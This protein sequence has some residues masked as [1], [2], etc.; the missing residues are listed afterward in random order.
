[1]GYEL[2]ARAW[3]SDILVHTMI[4]HATG[5]HSASPAPWFQILD[6]LFTHVVYSRKFFSFLSP[7]VAEDSVVYSAACMRS[8]EAV[9][10]S[11]EN[12]GR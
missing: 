11:S 1:M 5:G 6:Y 7:W 9:H 4:S 8:S 12:D 2:K 3:R 10:E